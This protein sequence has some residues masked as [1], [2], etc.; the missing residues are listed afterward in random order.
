MN[1]YCLIAGLIISLLHPQISVAATISGFQ[2]YD[3]VR[4]DTLPDNFFLYNGRVWHNL[5]SEV[6]EDQFLFSDAFFF[7][8][9]MVS[10]VI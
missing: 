6:E 7:G 3:P 10:D 5:Y 8:R 4:Q 2:K 1:R 9:V